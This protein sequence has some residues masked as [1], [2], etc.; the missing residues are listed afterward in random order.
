MS[1][2]PRPVTAAALLD[3]ADARF[4]AAARLR[5]A[6]LQPYLA[7]AVYGL[8][9]VEAPG[10]GTFAVDG[11]WRLYLDMEKARSWGIEASA[12]VLLH[13]AHHVLRD[14][15]GR[16]VRAGVDGSHQQRL[17][18]LA[19]DA[20]INDD[21]RADGAPL[22]IGVFP[23]TLGAP[24]HLLEEAYYQHLL[25]DE[26]TGEDPGCGSGSGNG[27]ADCEVPGPDD[28]SEEGSG[29]PAG[30]DAVDAGA[31]RRAVAHEIEAAAA[32]AHRHGPSPRLTRWAD[33]LLRPQVPWRQ[34]LRG[35]F[36]HELRA[37]TG[38]PWPTFSRPDRRADAWPHLVRPGIRRSAA[39]VAVVIDTSASMTTPLIE[40]AVAEIDA[41]LHKAG[42]HHV[43]VFNCDHEVATPQ[44]VRRVGSLR[45]TGGGG[46][47]LRVGIA[48]AADTRPQP[49]VIAVLT[50][51]LT[52]WPPA[53]PRGTALIAVLIGDDADL[54]SGPGI[55]AIRVEGTR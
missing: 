1:T 54:P 30:L 3:P 55:T 28:E 39:E 41:L 7:A 48:A 22:P 21:L 33:E 35:A 24:S 29:L 17:W 2:R 15:D 23:E 18:N 49:S 40:A 25:R 11:Y 43:T 27:A 9:P 36:R 50:D 8:V 42:V 14:H 53:A 45:L 10:L 47:D 20:A 13:E 16:A 4:V 52:P 51:G 34:L 37:V 31:I 26:A 38:T 32:A 5:A 6:R 44:V 19:G 12:A 46:T